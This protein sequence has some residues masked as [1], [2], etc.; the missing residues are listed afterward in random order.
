[1]QKRFAAFPNLTFRDRTEAVPDLWSEAGEDTLT[2]VYFRMLREISETDPRAE[3][4]A[5]ISQRI[6]SGGEVSLL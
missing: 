2:G 5:K 6:L 1:M 4:A 3:L